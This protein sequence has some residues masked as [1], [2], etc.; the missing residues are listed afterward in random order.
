MSELLNQL[1]SMD[2][3]SLI[4]KSNFVETVGKYITDNGYSIV[5]LND[6]KPWGAYFR[7]DNDNADA[8]IAEFFPGLTPIEARLG[9][10]DLELSPKILI[11]SPGQ[12]LSWQ[13]HNR[14]AER[15]AFLTDG[16]Y[17]KSMNN[18][19]GE[20][21]SARAGDVVQFDRNERHRLVG[22][23]DTYAL[24]AEIWQHTDPAEPSDEDDIVRLQDDYK[25]D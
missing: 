6:E 17:N 2:V 18:D 23:S 25:R 22:Q 8:F 16:A 20:L 15:W 3:N 4:Q 7:F 10:D 5:E 11:V 13:Y 1:S 24:V 21:F 19:E 9:R 12:R 14:R